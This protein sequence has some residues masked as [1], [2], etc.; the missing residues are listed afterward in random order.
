MLAIVAAILFGLALLLDL[1]NQSL[2]TVITVQTLL[3]AGLLCVALHLAGV[4]GHRGLRS[5]RG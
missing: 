2:G 1:I 5:G 3:L 4:G